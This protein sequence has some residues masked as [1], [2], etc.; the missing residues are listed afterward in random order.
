M[1]P[2]TINNFAKKF[3]PAIFLLLITAMA[4]RAQQDNYK[5]LTGRWRTRYSNGKFYDMQF[6]T[7]STGALLFPDGM[8]SAYINIK[9]LPTTKPGLI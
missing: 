6:I 4:A 9:Y 3:I 1:K 5:R 8:L 2:A 7:D